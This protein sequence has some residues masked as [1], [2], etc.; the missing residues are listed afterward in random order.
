MI[1]LY[2]CLFSKLQTLLKNTTLPNVT[3]N[4]YYQSTGLLETQLSRAEKAGF[5]L[6]VG[7]VDA[8]RQYNVTDIRRRRMLVTQI[9]AFLSLEA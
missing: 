7:R 3:S 2:F 6:S 5:T 1:F 8:F 9:S 4:L